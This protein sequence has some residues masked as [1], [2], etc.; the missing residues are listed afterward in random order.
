MNAVPSTIHRAR[1][2]V[3]TLLD[4]TNKRSY[5]KY[6]QMFVPTRAGYLG[7][8]GICPTSSRSRCRER[9][10]GNYRD[11]ECRPLAGALLVID[12]AFT[13]RVATDLA[14][15]P[16]D[17]RPCA[18]VPHASLARSILCEHIAGRRIPVGIPFE[19]SN[20]SLPATRSL[21]QS[22]PVLGVDE[23]SHPPRSFGPEGAVVIAWSNA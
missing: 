16:A 6:E 19:K 9:G 4:S 12:S 11:L 14:T 10:V 21:E 8:L 5:S 1:V 22:N 7:L 3:P 17:R 23:G 13:W 20:A 18:D 15:W 2:P